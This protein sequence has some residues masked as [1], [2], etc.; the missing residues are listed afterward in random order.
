MASEPAEGAFN[1]PAPGEYVE[2]LKVIVSFDDL[3]RPRCEFLDPVDE[4]ARIPAVGPYQRES[5]ELSLQSLEN[6]LGAIA[7]LDAGFM[8]DDGQDQS[9]RVHHQMAFASVDFLARVIPAR[10][11]FSVVFTD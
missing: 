8:N 3:E 1:N 10:P 4:F 2:A 11:P 7:I 6:E 5:R 9:D